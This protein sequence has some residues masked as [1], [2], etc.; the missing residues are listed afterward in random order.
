MLN[1]AAER[2][3]D[4]GEMTEAAFERQYKMFLDSKARRAR[5]KSRGLDQNADIRKSQRNS[6]AHT[7]QRRPRADVADG[8]SRAPFEDNPP[9]A[10]WAVSSAEELLNRCGVSISMM[11]VFLRASGDLDELMRALKKKLIGLN[12][13]RERAG[14]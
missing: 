5:R 2:V 3:A 10:D 12:R 4:G 8:I 13:E 7:A 11:L 14:Q 1:A 9:L 6:P